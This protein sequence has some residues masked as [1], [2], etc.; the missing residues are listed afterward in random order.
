MKTTA[1]DLSSPPAGDACVANIGP[2]ERRQRLLIGSIGAAVCAAVSVAFVLDG[3][4]RAWRLT[5]F[6]P[7][8]ISMLGLLQSRA[9]TCVALAARG[10][11]QLGGAPEALPSADLEKVQAQAR[12]VLFRSFVLAAAITA[13]SL[14]P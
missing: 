5:L 14:V 13:L 6:L 2:S 10:Q 7:W 4:G 12:G 8:W 9:Q 1:D 11:R 3:V